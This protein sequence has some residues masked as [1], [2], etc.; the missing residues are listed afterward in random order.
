MSLYYTAKELRKPRNQTKGIKSMIDIVEM[1]LLQ[2]RWETAGQVHL[3]V[4]QCMV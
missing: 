3:C 2:R 4:W 1:L